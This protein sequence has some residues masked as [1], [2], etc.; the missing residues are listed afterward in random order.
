MDKKNIPNTKDAHKKRLSGARLLDLATSAAILASLFSSTPDYAQTSS[1]PVDAQ[2]KNTLEL[3]ENRGSMEHQKIIKENVKNI[4]GIYGQEK[5]MEIIR[6]HVLEQI[7]KKRSELG[8]TPLKLH[9][10]MNALAQSKAKDMA[11]NEYFDHVDIEGNSDAG[12]MI[13]DGRYNFQMFWSN[14]SYNIKTIEDVIQSYINNDKRKTGH[15]DV[16]SIKDYEDLWV[17][18]AKGKNGIVYVVVNYGKELKKK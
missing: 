4:L 15:Y 16:I 18:L 17:G 2:K 5:W 8:N 7:N 14:I 6:E 13:K 3:V 9:P 11:D 12:R 1:Y 10:I